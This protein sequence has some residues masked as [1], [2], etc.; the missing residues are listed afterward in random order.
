MQK[1]N[2]LLK[3]IKEITAHRAHLDN[4]VNM[5]KHHLLGGGHGP[6]RG[7]GSALVDDWGCLKFMVKKAKYSCLLHVPYFR[8]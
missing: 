3:K 5:I 8:F 7:E 4:S 1:K 2:E 6:A